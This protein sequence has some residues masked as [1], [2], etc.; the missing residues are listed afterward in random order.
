MV[1][2]LSKVLKRPPKNSNSFI[3]IR[4][5]EETKKDFNIFVDACCY[6]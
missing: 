3:L 6:K 1:V 5:F 2:T 4:L